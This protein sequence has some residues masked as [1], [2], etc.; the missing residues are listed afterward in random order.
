MRT[1]DLIRSAAGNVLRSK[2]RTALAGIAVLIG[3]FTLVLTVGVGS[4]VNAYIADTVNSIGAPT[5][6]ELSRS[7]DTEDGDL[8]VY[9]PNAGTVTGPGLSGTGLGITE[10]QLEEARALPGVVSVE[11]IDT[12]L[13]DY[14]QRPGHAQYASGLNAP[15]HDNVFQM[16]TGTEPDDESSDYEVAVPPTYVTALDYADEAAIIGDEIVFGFRDQGGSTHTVTA[17]VTGVILPSVVP[18]TTPV[19]NA[20]LIND[21]ADTQAAGG[22]STAAPIASASLVFDVDL[23]EAEV[24]Q[25]KDDLAALGLEGATVSDRIGTFKAVI[26]GIVLI[27]AAFACIALLAA[28]FGV[29]NTL[30]MS[31]QERTREIGLLK[32]LGTSSLRIF[33]QFALEAIVIGLLGALIGG[34]LAVIAGMVAN[35]ILQDGVLSTLPGLSV[36]AADPLTLLLVLAAILA[37]TFIAGTAPAIRAARKEPIE[38]L[39]YE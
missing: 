39:R 34:G 4:G 27:L 29:A 20:A 35:S 17:T 10:Q 12:I 25:L 37:I 23:T 7:D 32:A 2:L 22:A 18:V 3:S 38:A 6:M 16:S 5:T 28:S 24:V 13:V 15:Q 9:D 11:P 36:Y 26:D 33:S 30:L 21:V 31:V 1:T 8:P 19:G 14:V